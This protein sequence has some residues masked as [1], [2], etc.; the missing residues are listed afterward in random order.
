MG[1]HLTSDQ[2]RGRVHVIIDGEDKVLRFDQGALVRVIEVL[3]LDGLH[4]LPEVLRSLDGDVLRALMW[5]GCLHEDE[6]LELSDVAK[7][8]Y[9]ALPS[10]MACLEGIN[11]AIW[12][13]PDGPEKEESNDDEN[14]REPTAATLGTSEKP[15]APLSDVSSSDSES[16][17]E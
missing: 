14:P 11:L 16:S 8:F 17:G 7:W 15:S 3:G 10:F 4:K 2:F 13:R 6:N 5:A 9:P 12:G 1:K